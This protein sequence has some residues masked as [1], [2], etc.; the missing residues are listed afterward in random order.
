MANIM[1]LVAQWYKNKVSGKE[2]PDHIGH[3]DRIWILF[4]KEQEVTGGS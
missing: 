4:H 1:R 3:G 2:A